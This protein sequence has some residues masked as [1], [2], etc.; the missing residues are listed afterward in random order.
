MFSIIGVHVVNLIYSPMKDLNYFNHRV[1]ILFSD[2][3]HNKVDLDQFIHKLRLIEAWYKQ[4]IDDE[5]SDK[6]IYFKFAE[7]DTV[8]TTIDD[9]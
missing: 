4:T 3:L 2:Y 1:S 7:D 6:S 8:V 9:L 5:S